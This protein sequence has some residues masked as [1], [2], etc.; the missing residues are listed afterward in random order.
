MQNKDLFN[1]L[2]GDN[3]IVIQN[4]DDLMNHASFLF[5]QGFLSMEFKIKTRFDFFLWQIKEKC[6]KYEAAY[7]Y[8]DLYILFLRAIDEAIE[9]TENEEGPVID[10]FVKTIYRNPNKAL[11]FTGNFIH[12]SIVKPINNKT[13]LSR[14]IEHIIASGLNH[15]GHKNINQKTPKD[16]GSTWG[17]LNSIIGSNFKPQFTSI[18]SIREYRYNANNPPTEIRMGTQAQIHHN[19]PKVSPTFRKWLKTLPN[20]GQVQHIYFNSLRQNNSGFFDIE[21]K[22]ERSM[23]EALN[24]LENDFKNVAIITLPSSHG[25]ISL[26][27]HNK[28]NLTLS[29]WK[30]KILDIALE[31]GYGPKIEDF[32]ISE[33]IRE[34]IFAGMEREN[35]LTELIQNSFVKLGYNDP[36]AIINPAQQQAIYF[37]FIKYELTKFIINQ[38]NPSSI[39][40]SCKDGIDRGGI[41]SAYYNLIS[42]IESGLAMTEEEF[43]RALHAAPA[44]VKGRGMNNNIERLWN[45]IN[46]YIDA[47]KGNKNIPDWLYTWRDDYGPKNSKYDFIKRLVNYISI[48]T[49][50]AS[51]K[52]SPRNSFFGKYCASEKIEIANKLLS[53]LKDDQRLHVFLPKDLELLNDGRLKAIF[54]DLKK[55]GYVADEPQQHNHQWKHVKVHKIPRNPVRISWRRH[56]DQ[57]EEQGPKPGTRQDSNAEDRGNAFKIK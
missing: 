45:A 1:N 19:K 39:N 37:D 2:D 40:F 5:L 27:R 48:R 38:L 3:Q 11:K 31:N 57:H 14:N 24:T 13:N 53:N 28:K 29:E 10:E 49:E 56:Q 15:N 23:T 16:A 43:T 20:S 9:K 47:Q 12:S 50:E 34:K 30:K 18:P 6:H 44:L 17:R 22:R 26:D 33:Q 36:H 7:P 46:A 21:G 52:N 51:K 35:K 54:S 8:G 55:F 25:A 4:S 32:H 42:S 41:A